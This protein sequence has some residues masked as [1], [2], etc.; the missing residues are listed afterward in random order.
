MRLIRSLSPLLAVVLTAAV[1][2]LGLAAQSP[3]LH[4]SLCAAHEIGLDHDHDHAHEHQHHAA[5]EGH[6]DCDGPAD[7]PQDLT[8]EHSCAVTLFA[9][10]CTPSVPLVFVS[11]PALTATAVAQFE[12][13]LLSRTLRGPER[14]CGPPHQA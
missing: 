11:A 3:A 13:L 7:K 14:V 10:G 2:L 8:P 12:A 6:A 9:H 5:H 4:R 1:L